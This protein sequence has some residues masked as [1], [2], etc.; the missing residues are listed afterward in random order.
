MAIQNESSTNTNNTIDTYFEMT[1]ADTYTLSDISLINF[2]QVQIQ[3]LS[4]D[5]VFVE[6]NGNSTNMSWITLLNDDSTPVNPFDGADG[7]FP[8]K[9]LDG[10]DEFRL[11]RVGTA[12]GTIKVN[13]TQKTIKNN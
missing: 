11:R 5:E 4:A 9:D 3:G 7:S 6:I 1:G 10:I 12:D 13:L 2:I 8:I